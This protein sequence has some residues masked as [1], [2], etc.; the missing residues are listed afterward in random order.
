MDNNR[1]QF[2]VVVVGAGPAGMMA[3]GKAA[4]N[5]ARVLLIDK[6]KDP[7][8]KLLMTGQGRC[9]I[10]Q[11][12]YGRQEFIQKLGSSGKF[13]HSSFSFF[14]PKDV[15]AF[16]NQKDLETKTE[17]GGRVFPTTD[18]AD[19]V[20]DI[21][22]KYLQQGNVEMMTGRKVIGFTKK[23]EKIEC[24]KLKKEKVYANNFI[25]ST[26]GKSYPTTGSTG[27]GYTW[28][29]KLGHTIIPLAPSLSP[30][31]TKEKWINELQGLSLKNVQLDI[32]QNDKKHDSRFGEMLFTHFGISGP[33]T[34]DM[35]KEIYQ[36]LKNGR[37]FAR[38]DLKPALDFTKLDN[39]LQRDLLQDAKKDFKNY[40]PTLLPKKLIPV[41]IKL[42][43]IEPSRKLHSI[44]K[45]ERK[46][47]VNLL[48]GL[49]FEISGSTGFNHAIVTSGGVDTKE[50]DSKT[51][52]SRK[53]EN[54]FFAGEV[55]DLD[56]PTGGF[57]L[58]ICWSTG[59][60]AGSYCYKKMKKVFSRVN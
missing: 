1:K 55:L 13:L 22:K 7:G 53:I 9:N 45:Q 38:I 42:S 10:T 17:R 43:K 31:N 24:V 44:N 12:K 36:L 32:F 14:G 51:M 25:I 33:I 29:R 52:R 56:G 28:A 47:L 39:R 49:S 48:K 41:I 57:N 15:V 27:D 21:L 8:K 59:F 4:E 46:A 58:Q 50:V 5:G 35:S 3:A 23:N 2:D 18:K 11:V 34:L 20:L 26:G 19:D 60:S 16:F 30:L 37:V 40:L 6:N 54:L